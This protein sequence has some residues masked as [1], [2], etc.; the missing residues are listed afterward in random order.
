MST[1]LQTIVFRPATAVLVAFLGCACDPTAEIAPS[2]PAPDGDGGSWGDVSPDGGCAPSK[3]AT[4]PEW[5]GEPPPFL[6]DVH[7]PVASKD[8][9]PNELDRGTDLQ[10]LEL[11]AADA[12]CNDGTHAQLYVRPATAGNEKKWVLYLQGGG[13]CVGYA[14]CLS[15]WRGTQEGGYDATKMST[16]YNPDTALAEGIFERSTRNPLSGW[17]HVY[18]YSCSSDAFSGT[19]PNAILFDPADQQAKPYSLYFLGRRILE[20]AL[21]QLRNGAVATLKDSPGTVPYRMPALRDAEVVLLAGSSAGA[22]AVR[23]NADWVGSQLGVSVR[24][25]AIAEATVTTPA[26]RYGGEQGAKHDECSAR[27]T[28]AS[29]AHPNGPRTALDESCRAAHEATGDAWL[30]LD[31]HHLLH[32]HIT[33]PMMLRHDLTDPKSDAIPRA[34]GLTETQWVAIQNTYFQTLVDRT[35]FSHAPEPLA[36][37]PSF[38]APNCG[39]HIVFHKGWYYDHKVKSEGAEVSM[40]DAVARWLKGGKPFYVGDINGTSSSCTK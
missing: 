28:Y 36:Q 22:V 32:H 24:Y 26:A 4:L 19:N 25:A 40:N 2:L 27:D 34:I 1:D 14:D 8:K 16:R 12:L 39:A 15:R 5:D 20:G 35:E 30:C 10:R 21:A 31:T 6:A 11:T 17:N 9:Y 38:F 37:A 3:G 7:E 33:T 13:G 23:R 18:F 29:R